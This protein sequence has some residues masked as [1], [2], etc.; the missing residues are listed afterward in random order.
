MGD[1]TGSTQHGE[2]HR[3]NEAV[4]ALSQLR[5]KEEEGNAE[6]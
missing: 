6:N 3:G 4:A 5:A 2:R 1:G